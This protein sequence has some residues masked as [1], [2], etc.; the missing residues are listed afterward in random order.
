[1]IHDLKKQ[2]LSHTAIGQQLG[3]SR[4]TVARRLKQELAGSGLWAEGIEAA[5]DW[6]L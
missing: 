1:M 6:A 5:P 3:I 2:G 4:R